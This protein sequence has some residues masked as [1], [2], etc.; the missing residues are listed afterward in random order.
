MMFRFRAREIQTLGLFSSKK[1]YL[2]KLVTV[3][4][5]EHHDALF[6][7]LHAIHRTD[8]YYQ[9]PMAVWAFIVEDIHH[10]IIYACYLSL[11]WSKYAYLIEEVFTVRKVLHQPVD[12]NGS[13][14]SFDVICNYFTST[15]CIMPV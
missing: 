10:L 12:T 7:F 3:C 8:M 4:C 14:T 15:F 2:T 5:A 11:I 13:N 9:C 1:S 6:R